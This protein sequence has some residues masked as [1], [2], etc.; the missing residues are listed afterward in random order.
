MVTVSRKKQRSNLD[1]FDTL[2]IKPYE[3]KVLRIESYA[4]QR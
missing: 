4:S 1:T 2:K 3:T